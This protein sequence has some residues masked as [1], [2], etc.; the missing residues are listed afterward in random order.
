MA[1]KADAW[2]EYKEAAMV[3]MML[4]VNKPNLYCADLRKRFSLSFYLNLNPN[5]NPNPNCNYWFSF[6]IGEKLF[7]CPRCGA[8]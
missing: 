5:P 3:D 4:K 8:R 2:K 1:K 7:V 6:V